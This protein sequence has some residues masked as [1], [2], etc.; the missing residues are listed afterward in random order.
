MNVF[1]AAAEAVA[2]GRAA[3]LVTVVGVGG[4]APRSAGARMLVYQDGAIVGTIGGGHFEHVVVGE[5]REAI[6]TGRPRRFHAHLTR[7][8]GMCCGGHMEA[9]IEPLESTPDLVIHGAGHV[10]SATARL[11]AIA[12]FRVTVVDDRSDLLADAD[13]PTGA[14][15]LDGDPRRLLDQLPMGPNAYHLVVTHDH[16]LDQDLVERLLPLPHAWLG[17]IGSR[18]KV[19]RFAVRLRAAGTDPELFARLHAPVGLDIGAETPGEIGVSI[20]AELVRVRRACER[21]P[22]PLTIAGRIDR[23]R[24]AD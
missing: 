17:L 4:S 10:G 9:Y 18:A 1:E 12:G 15:R 19:A 14:T 22:L 6:R 3:A 21:T 16:A 24:D 20:V 7:D 8:L 23:Q 2:R 5:A 11:A 13:L